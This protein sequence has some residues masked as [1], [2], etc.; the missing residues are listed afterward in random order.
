MYICYVILSNLKSHAGVVLVQTQII[1]L[2]M[3][4]AQICILQ[5][6]LV[7]FSHRRR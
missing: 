2:G 1:L 4:L 6:F 7:F 5:T 3:I